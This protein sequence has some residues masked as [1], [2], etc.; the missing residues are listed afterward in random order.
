M[1]IQLTKE[2]EDRLSRKVTSGP[3]TSEGEVVR[4]GLDLLEH[5][6]ALRRAV[7]ESKAQLA[8]GQV[9]TEPESRTRISKP[10]ADLEE[11]HSLPNGRAVTFDPRGSRTSPGWTT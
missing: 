11:S 5:S 6:E 10:L 7:A 8:R 9:V 1:A 3:H 4:A 2:T